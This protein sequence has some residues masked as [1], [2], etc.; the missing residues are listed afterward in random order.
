ME[1]HDLLGRLKVVK[2]PSGSGEYTA[3]CPGH[4]DR[5]ASLCIRA[6]DKGIVLKCQAGCS[7]DN[8]CRALGIDVK[9]L[10]YRTTDG[11]KPQ[12]ERVGQKKDADLVPGMKVRTQKQFS[13]YA[14][15]YGHLGTVEKVY[16]YCSEK[17]DLIFEVARIRTADGGKTFR[18]HRPVNA[19]K[20]T[21]P[22][23]CSVP[24]EI[25][26]AAL[27]RRNEIS[28]AV[29]KGM[30]VYVVEG[31]KDA[32]TIAGFGYCG[33]TNPG[34]AGKWTKEHS[35]QLRGADVV[36]IPDED[37]ESNGRAGQAHGEAVVSATLGVAKSV[38]LIRLKDAYP[39]LPDKG[40]I[41]DLVALIGAD[42]AKAILDDLVKKTLPAEKDMY[43]K[44]I[45]VYDSLPGFCVDGGCTCRVLADGKMSAM[46]TFVALPVRQVLKDDGV[47]TS[48]WL[49]IDGW[50]S[51]GYPLPRLM[52][53]R[54]K[55]SS[56]DWIGSW[57]L[58]AVIMTGNSIKD[59]LRCAIE[60]VGA[61]TAK[62]ETMYT[63]YGWRKLSKG[64]CYLYQGGCIGADQATVDLGEGLTAYSLDGYP[65]E[66]SRVDAAYASMNLSNVI[67]QRVSVPMLGVTYLAPL[68]EFL[69]QA[70]CD[71]AFAV[72]LYGRTG[73]RKSTAA[74]LF[75]SHFGNFT[76]RSLP[77]SF[78]D[79]SN[80]I[81]RKA[82][83]IKD[84]LLVVD[85]YHPTSSVQ[86]RR[87]MERTAQSLARAFGDN[88][89]RGRLGA[90]LSIQTS[91]PP[92]SLAVISG[93]DVPDIGESG[94][95]RYYIINVEG[96]D[97]PASNDLT[98]MQQQAQSGELRA[99]MRGYIEWLIPQADNLSDELAE[100]FY[101]Y[102]A[103]AQECFKGGNV[104]GRTVEAVAQVMIGLTMMNRYFASLGIYTPELAASVTEELWSVV[105]EN[106]L[107]QSESTR[108]D[109]PSMMFISALRELLAS[110]A[111]TVV[112]ISPGFGNVIPDVHMIG[113]SDASNYYLL[114]ESS[115]GAV[116]KFYRDQDRL[117]PVKRGALY[118][119]LVTDG[120]VVD[121]DSGKSTKLKRIPD[122]K[123]Q[124]LLW[125]PR[126]CIDGEKPY[127][128]RQEKMEFIPEPDDDIPEE[129][130]GK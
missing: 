4:D 31:E 42:K 77:A 90:D 60:L 9:D 45:E 41:S 93:E 66:L 25:R 40:D 67:S 53:N 78:N 33:T 111:A 44:A 50:D 122:G 54:S 58:D 118:K 104:H 6:G 56:M 107:A 112:D 38:K 126:K 127:K 20:G 108:D 18:Q 76:S 119:E 51:M 95:S 63:H 117:F 39:E 15:A 98:E 129:F 114:G 55:F 121:F 7:C 120:I 30:P 27:Y 81:R 13:S 19:K 74:A 87:T 124:R 23:V 26:G 70:G 71:P 12:A 61:K 84:A 8:V 1:L 91:M 43:R 82:F 123:L 46:S 35:A 89:E 110:K 75:L 92:R 57:P 47:Q 69:A 106:S 102:R 3:K 64:W 109:K 59:R 68:R 130:G 80:Y 79:T 62:K 28:A 10:F 113:Y 36:V 49:E 88:A 115:F 32:D 101:A 2:G 85:D 73:S 105:T 24:A 125:I 37:P 11:S 14:A 100:M 34:G 83:A 17:G 21:F 96:N 65:E 72:F 5:Q 52:V 86:E 103:R 128:P 22:F 48:L 16:P 29:R 99:A 94:V 97:V 116:V